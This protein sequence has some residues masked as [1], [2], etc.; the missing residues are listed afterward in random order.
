MLRKRE[1]K[2]IVPFRSYPMRNRKF[3][4]NS[5]KIQKIKKYHSGFISTFFVGKVRERAKIKIIVPF[6]SYP[7]HNGKFQKNSKEIKNIKKIPL[8]LHFKPKQVGE[9]QERGK[10][11]IIV[12]FRSWPKG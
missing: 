9:G 4:K 1:I 12:P 5:K 2:I 3:Q 10:I 6:R 11:K 8:W 7:M